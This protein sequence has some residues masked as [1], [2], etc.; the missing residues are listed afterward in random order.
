MQRVL[1]AGCGYVGAAAAELFQ[2]AGWEVEG[3]TRTG[4]G[5]LEAP[6]GYDLRAIDLSDERQVRAAPGTFDLVIQAASTRG[7]GAAAYRH[8]YLEGARH[9]L[10]RFTG[11]A[12]LFVSS[13]SVY[14][15]RT[16]EW[17]TEASR[18]EPEHETGHILRATEDLV[19]ER[20]GTVARFAGIYGPGR[21]ALLR[22]VLRSEAVVNP[23]DDRFVNQVHRADAASAL[24]RLG[25]DA[26]M[27]GIYNVV[28]DLPLPLSECYRWLA[29]RL[30]RTIPSSGLAPAAH[31]RG[32]T[33]KRVSNARIRGAG[34]APRFPSFMEGMEK[35]V[36]PGMDERCF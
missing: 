22:R 1:M 15:Q 19:L 26:A 6:P 12:F 28:D 18:A 8:L 13:T 21:S 33:N 30:Q 36:L 34:W 9:L 20:G 7:G 25:G 2:E 24:Y 32:N 27:V 10:E 31:K 4:P 16:G 14:G 3:W 17:V 29:E 23:G 35:S 11:A 5:A